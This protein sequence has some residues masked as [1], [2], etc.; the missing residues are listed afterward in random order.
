MRTMDS[1]NNEIIKYLELRIQ[2]SFSRVFTWI[3]KQKHF[4]E[5]KLQLK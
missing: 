1:V 4:L 3:G 5:H 2:A